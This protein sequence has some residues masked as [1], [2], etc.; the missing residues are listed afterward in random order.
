MHLPYYEIIDDINKGPFFHIKI[1]PKA[2]LPGKPTVP[3]ETTTPKP[4]GTPDIPGYS[5]DDVPGSHLSTEKKDRAKTG[6]ESQITGFAVL[7]GMSAVVVCIVI[8]RKRKVS[9]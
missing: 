2:S 8:R 7:L 1:N 6:D 9:E 5:G 4:A 3:L